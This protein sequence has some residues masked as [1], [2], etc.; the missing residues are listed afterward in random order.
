M[1]VSRK[2]ASTKTARPRV[3]AAGRSAA[4]AP[5]T[6]AVRRETSIEL[7]LA[8]AL[9]LFVSQGYRSTNLEQISGAAHLSKGAV[10]FYFGSKEAMLLG[11]LQRVQSIVVDQCIAQVAG[12]D[13]SPQ[14]QLVAY[15]H[16]QANLG[17]TARDEVLLLILMS[18]EFKEREGEV[19]ACIDT[20]YQRQRAFVQRLIAAG[21]ASG[22]F[23]K[24][25]PSRELA[26]IVLAANDGTFLE[27][28]RRSERLT[29]GT[30]VRALRT[31]VLGGVC[32]PTIKPR[33][34]ARRG[35]PA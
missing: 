26:A 11:L 16:Y 24:D 2:V 9:R 4:V 18:L 14:A 5:T 25:L 30:L 32:A 35:L 31:L 3:A 1:A 19:K 29:G 12:A 13:P 33:A 8:A 17:I 22:E 21:Q 23:R 10:Y 15:I 7:L 27:W 34:S 6:Q 20:L 28:F